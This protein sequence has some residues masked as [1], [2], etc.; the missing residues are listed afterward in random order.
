MSA[1][2]GL[3]RLQ[4]IDLA[5]AQA[6]NRLD[7]IQAILSN[8]QELL[9]AVGRAETAAAER[10]SAE[11]ELAQLEGEA[12]TVRIKIEQAEASLYGGAVHNPKELQ[13][14]QMDVAALKRR[15]SALEDRQ[16]EAMLATE[17]VVLAEEQAAAALDQV[18]SQRGQQQVD[19]AGEQSAL[20]RELER[21]SAERNAAEGSL[22]ADQRMMYET[23]REE[24]RG[25]AVAE[26]SENACAACG[27]TL[28]PAQLQNVR[29]SPQLVACPTCG[30]VLYAG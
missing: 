28:T 27:T 23:L 6:R 19:L 15:Q 21:L 29:I 30:R 14:L 1:A 22:S 16:L 4:Q 24:K 7:A 2:L 5:I 11:S 17:A 13:D 12:G 9:E 3:Y 18:R 26:L 25:V 8:D 10:Q 20:S